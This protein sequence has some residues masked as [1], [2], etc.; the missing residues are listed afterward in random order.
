MTETVERLM[1][2][3]A[4]LSQ[5]DRTELAYFLVQSLDEGTDRDAEPAWDA[6]LARRIEDI[7]SGHAVGRPAEDVFRTLREKYP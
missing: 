5:A 7:K 3:L 2:Q 6:E 1:G 4:L